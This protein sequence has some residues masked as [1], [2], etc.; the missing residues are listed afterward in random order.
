VLEFCEDFAVWPYEM[1]SQQLFLVLATQSA[2]LFVHRPRYA[3]S[4]V[5]GDKFIY[6][7]YVLCILQEKIFLF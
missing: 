3:M 2:A 7:F 4:V 6:G 1:L 5:H